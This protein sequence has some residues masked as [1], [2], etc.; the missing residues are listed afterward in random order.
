MDIV[1]SNIG[2]LVT[3][4][5]HGGT[6]ND[7]HEVLSIARDVELCIHKGRIVNDVP[8]RSPDCCKILDADGGVVIPGLIDPFWL[9]P[10]KPVW[11]ETNGTAPGADE[12][13]WMERMLHHV[14]TS[15]VTTIELKCPHC[16]GLEDLLRLERA[17]RNAGPRV[18][19]SLL[20]TLEE[21]GT[22]PERQLSS[23][24]GEIIPEIRQRKLAAFVDIGWATHRDFV[25]EARTVMRAAGG[26]GL[27]CKLH[28]LIPPTPAELAALIAGQD[29]ASI[30]CASYVP[31]EMTIAWSGDGVIPVFLPRLGDGHGTCDLGPLLDGRLPFAIASGNGLRTGAPNSMWDVLSASM[32]TYGLTLP[33]GLAAATLGNAMALELDH[34]VGSLEPGKRADAIVLGLSDYREL[35]LTMG[36][37][38]IRCVIAGGEVVYP[39]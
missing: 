22:D 2:Q 17:K 12:P 24:I 36:F 10:E 33:E 38:P 7:T 18:I 3:P 6:A 30:G 14:V 4:V 35:E 23:L 9:V 25:A 37:S 8:S 13:H 5:A 1:I 11:M 34:E 27:R 16:I 15:G 20:T 32:E 26:A 29:L 19:G 31:M 28:F 21:G 39:S